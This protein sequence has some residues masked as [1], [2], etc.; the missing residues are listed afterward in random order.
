MFRTKGHKRFLSPDDSTTDS[1]SS[2]DKRFAI[3]SGMFNDDDTTA[4]IPM[5]T[6]TLAP[7]QP[8]VAPG[9]PPGTSSLGSGNNRNGGG[10]FMFSGNS[11][12]GHTWYKE[13]KKT[14]RFSLNTSLPAYKLYNASTTTPDAQYINYKPGS[15]Y[16]ILVDYV[17]SY[18]SP[19]EFWS[20][21][22][23]CKTAEIVECS[24]EVYSEG[25]RLP[26]TTA[27]TTALT[28]NA[29]A[30]YPIC[31]WKGL[32]KDWPVSQEISARRDTQ[33]KMIGGRFDQ[34]ISDNSDV[35]NENFPNLSARSTS[36]VYENE[37]VVLIPAPC[38]AIDDTQAGREFMATMADVNIHEYAHTKN[39]TTELGKVFDYHYKPKNG[40][41]IIQ[42]TN[43]PRRG[44]QAVDHNLDQHD[45]VFGHLQRSSA[46]IAMG[47]GAG[48]VTMDIQTE[49]GTQTPYKHLNPSQAVPAVQ[50]TYLECLVENQQIYHWDSQK[51]VHKQDMF[52]IGMHNI[53]NIGTSTTEGSLLRANW[54]VILVFKCKVKCSSGVR[55]LYS[56]NQNGPVG[57]FL[58]PAMQPGHMGCLD[59]GGLCS[60]TAANGLLL[61]SRHIDVAG[62]H[63]D[64]PKGIGNRNQLRASIRS[65]AEQ[66]LY[67]PPEAPTFLGRVT[68]ARG[69][70]RSTRLENIQKDIQE[71]RI[72]NKKIE[73]KKKNVDFVDDYGNKII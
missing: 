39:G 11:Q 73:K 35:W 63:I 40:M 4:S 66:Q 57:Q 56:M 19:E 68:D 43:I 53:R 36:R 16:A 70:M 48:Q 8:A 14:Y 38:Y 50:Q 55:G 72:K 49:A 24:C 23:S 45:T 15:M 60:D 41:F 5:D 27:E 1:D 28:A 21:Q 12:N 6:A 59:N 10:E 26:F 25:I 47:L 3:D 33:S 9:L 7:Q 64:G 34:L 2:Q 20:M 37:A 69:M 42:S 30:Q 62:G 61:N 54:E 17:S 29:S 32:D 22:K 67:Y 58:Y 31:Q 52:L 71:L 18:L 51:A 46:T 65:A 44:Y 13:F